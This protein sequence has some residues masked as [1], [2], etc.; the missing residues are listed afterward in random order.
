MMIVHHSHLL[1]RSF[2]S[3]SPGAKIPHSKNISDK[4]R[5]TETQREREPCLRIGA[6]TNHE[7]NMSTV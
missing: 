1:P 4:E 5:H 7:E 2:H 3:F 6:F